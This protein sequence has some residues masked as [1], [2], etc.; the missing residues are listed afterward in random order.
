MRRAAPRPRI[1][2]EVEPP[3]DEERRRG[4]EANPEAEATPALRIRGHD[5]PEGIARCHDTDPGNNRIED[6]EPRAL[7]GAERDG[8]GGETDVQDLPEP[9]EA[10]PWQRRHELGQAR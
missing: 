8:S 1:A 7:L 5:C 6:R 10:A 9:G 4:G 2:V 3:E